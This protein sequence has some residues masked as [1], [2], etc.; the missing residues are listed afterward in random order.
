MTTSK[1]AESL[2]VM[3][4]LAAWVTLASGCGG[5]IPLGAQENDGG[6]AGAGGV[7]GTSSAGAGGAK[8][9]AA[10]DAPVATGGSAGQ[11]ST[12]GKGGSGGNS[13][14]AGSPATG[15]SS[16]L[17]GSSAAGGAGR[18][19]S[20]SGGGSGGT[21]SGVILTAS[22]DGKIHATW[23]NR[24]SQSIFLNGCGTVNWSRLESSGWVSYGA[25]VSCAV[26]GVAIEVLAGASFAEDG[27]VS[28]AGTYRLSGAYGVGCTPGLG[29]SKAGCS[30]TFQATS[31]EF[32]ISIDGGTGSDGG[33]GTG[34]TTGGGGSTGK[35][36]GG[37]AGGMCAANQFC[38][39]P[40]SCG[41]I[42]NVTGTCAP[43]G[44]DGGCIA[45]DMPVCGCD[46]K[47]YGN[48]CE[49]MRV[50]VQKASEGACVTDAGVA[51]SD[52][53]AGTCSALTTQTACEAR[54]DCHA[55]FNDPNNCA[56]A[57]LGCCAKF[58]KCASGARANCSGPATC[59]TVT[60]HCEGQYT[61][62]YANSCFE[63]CVKSTACAPDAGT[64]TT[65]YPTAYLAWEVPGGMAGTGPV[66]VASGAGWLNTWDNVL[67]FVM[68]TP[69]TPPS[70]ATGT[71]TM[72][73]AQADD[74]FTR[75][76]AVNLSVLPHPTTQ[77][78]EAYPYLYFRLCTACKPVTL[79]YNLASQ[80]SP[81]ME[82]VWLW[83]DQ[84]LGAAA[85]TNP[86]NWGVP[87]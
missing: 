52:A 80:L 46:G 76:A 34:G 11:S 67:G 31:N 15:G 44:L 14:S 43:T 6:A 9:D 37:S 13:G 66:V 42:A 63:G 78:M 77:G 56:C 4:G 45:V 39:V 82:P 33:G 24:T 8:I 84:F 62:A 17:G 29:L 81:E 40:S 85:M 60:P 83:F 18:G 22:Y 50:G 48:D 1:R 32:V 25:F 16:A 58:S 65:S 86:R 28:K 47:T 19:G 73:R 5:N 72:S 87:F 55:V 54:S 70:N 79:K 21:L 59:N 53:L 64:V 61:V 51:P 3:V 75:L 68:D 12:G 20:T 30:S 36:C 49:R 69:E 35:T 71:H 2:Q 26:E 74:L 41:R 7:A 23:Q 38:D 57:A 27:L 10:V